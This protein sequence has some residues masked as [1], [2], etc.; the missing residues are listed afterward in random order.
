[1]IVDCFTFFDEFD[2]LE[3][4]LKELSGVVDRFVLAEARQ[5]FQGSPKP[6]YFQENATRFKQYLNKIEHLIV[7]LPETD[8]PWVREGYQRNAL[9][10]AIGQ[11][12]RDA[13]VFIS[14]VDE[15]FRPSAMREAASRG[16]F[17]FVEMDLYYY[18]LNLRSKGAKWV[19]P[20]C[21][22]AAEIMAIEDFSLP[23]W[24]ELQYLQERNL[25]Q[26]STVRSGGWHFSWLASRILNKLDSFSHT[27]LRIW[28]ERRGEIEAAVT[29][30]DKFFVTGE[31]LE[32]AGL[33]ELPVTV[34]KE[35]R[36]LRR[37][38]YFW[39]PMPWY[40]RIRKLK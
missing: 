10:R 4:R 25:P 28:R 40:R 2:V 32:R 5:T 12:P 8:D 22:P 38:G 27:D 24:R 6:L 26:D 33:Q 11:L 16:H 1:M 39:K 18:F 37:A 17:V 7:D 21:G 29:K 30:G 31:S 9:K 3:I 23:R 34:Q 36:R 19:K 20:Y 35:Y 15:I 13:T 14:D